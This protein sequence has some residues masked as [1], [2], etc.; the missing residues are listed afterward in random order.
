[1]KKLFAGLIVLA[2]IGVG[3][4]VFYKLGGFSDIVVSQSDL[5]QLEL[6][7]IYFVGT[8]TQTELRDAFSRMEAI[9]NSQS[10]PHLYTLYYREPAG[11][12]DTMEVFVGVEKRFVTNDTLQT[13]TLDASEAIVAT[14]QA[15]RFVMPGPNKVKTEIQEYADFAS[16]PRPVIFV[17]QIISADE[18]HV[19]GLQKADKPR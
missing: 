16:L 15:H 7:G 5:G 8:P 13:L 11:K 1:M 6:S 14:V 10:E 3:F 19:I 9:K 18:V 2:L 17:D 4:L 12:M